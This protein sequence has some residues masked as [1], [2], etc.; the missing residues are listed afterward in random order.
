MQEQ[1]SPP[2]EAEINQKLPQRYSPP[3]CVIDNCLCELR[4][5]KDNVSKKVLYNFTPWITAQETVYD[6]EKAFN[7][8]HL[9]GIAKTEDLCVRSNRCGGL[10]EY[11]LAARKMGCRL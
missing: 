5:T 3:Y 4:I 8:L 9:S 11:E 6:S 1:L 7:R 10:T 2:I